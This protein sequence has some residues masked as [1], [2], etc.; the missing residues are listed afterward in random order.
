VLAI[1]AMLLHTALKH[2]ELWLLRWKEEA[3]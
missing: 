1:I 2:A 3:R